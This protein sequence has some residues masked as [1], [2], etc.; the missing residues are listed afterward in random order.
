MDYKGKNI[1]VTGGAG[2]IG[3]H[4]CDRLIKT[5]IDKLVIVDNLFLGEDKI[6]NIQPLLNNKRVT[7]IK[8][9]STNYEL[10]KTLIQLNDIHSV[11]NFAVVPLLVSLKNPN[12]GFMENVRQTAVVGRLLYEREYYK[13]FHI[14][15]SEAYGSAMKIPMTEEHPM[16]PTTPYAASKAACD[17]LLLSYHKTHDLDIS[18]LRPFNNYGPRQNDGLYAGL[19]PITINRILDD[20]LPILEG[21]GQQ[22]RDFI[23]VED[24]V[25]AILRAGIY[26]DDIKGEVINI[27]SGAELSVDTVIRIICDVM[28]K[29]GLMFEER[30]DRMGD[31]S[32]H[33]GSN[34]KCTRLLNFK[35]PF[36]VTNFYKNIEKTVAYYRLKRKNRST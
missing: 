20:Q 31:V 22:T 4:F 30:P 33:Y 7:F 3:S 8:G 29:R 12:W 18:I 23:Y 6:D 17:H 36:S 19:I 24:T 25:E 11:F 2:F 10:M 34:E 16:N 32:R 1:L 14:S 27:C 21:G 9:D 15:S 5:G 28:D 13:L 26:S 35:Q